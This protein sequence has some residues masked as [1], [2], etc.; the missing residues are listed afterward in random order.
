MK[1]EDAV[2]QYISDHIG[3]L[4]ID[5][6]WKFSLDKLPIKIEFS[7]ESLLNQNINLRN[8]LHNEWKTATQEQR[9]LIISWYISEWGGVKAN[10]SE[11]LAIYASSEPEQLIKRKAAGIASWSKA[12]SVVDPFRFAIFDARVSSAINSIQIIKKVSNPRY[13]PD[14]PS[15]NKTIVSATAAA[16]TTV[17]KNWKSAS[18]DTFYQ[19]YNALLGNIAAEIGGGATLQTV[20]MVLFSRAEILAELANTRD[21]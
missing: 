3:M 7:N 14:L 9:L 5:Y 19:E 17:K 4:E 2:T 13:F 12:L 8:A 16:K 18:K 20:E 21:E 1:F 6:K 15:R 11:K 10:R